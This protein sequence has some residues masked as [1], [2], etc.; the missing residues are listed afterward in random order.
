[1]DRRRGDYSAYLKALA[2]P[3]E[4]ELLDVLGRSGGRRKADKVQV[5]EI[6]RAAGDGSTTFDF[7]VH[8]SRFPPA[9][10]A[11][12]ST[13]LAAT[14]V[15]DVLTLVPEPDNPVNPDALLVA[16]LAGVPSGWVPDLLVPYVNSIREAGGWALSVRRVNQPDTAWHARH[17][18]APATDGCGG[19]VAAGALR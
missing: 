17:A 7:L 18:H 12:V 19:D 11:A 1:M 15:G 14:L 13:A 6:P 3:P 5:A 10:E 4:A 9:G 2:L 8:G 16:T